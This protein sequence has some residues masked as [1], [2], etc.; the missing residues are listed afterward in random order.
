MAGINV[1]VNFILRQGIKKATEKFGKQSVD[2][3][4]QSKTFKRMSK[5]PPM[6][7]KDK[8]IFYGSLGAGAIGLTGAAAGLKSIKMADDFNKL[9]EERANAKKN[10]KNPSPPQM[11]KDKIKSSKKFDTYTRG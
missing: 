10:K 3:A 9:Q 5:D 2:K 8:I 1:V 7:M 6:T 4:R 11:D